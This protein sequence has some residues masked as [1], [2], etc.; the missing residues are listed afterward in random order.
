MCLSYRNKFTLKFWE[1]YLITQINYKTGSVR[2]SP[3]DMCTLEGWK[4][5]LGLGGRKW[6]SYEAQVYIYINVGKY[7]RLTS[8]LNTE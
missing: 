6:R 7:P 5:G 2:E 4:L 1:T 8:T 3:L